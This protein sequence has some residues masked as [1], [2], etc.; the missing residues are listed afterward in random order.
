MEAL[1][2]GWQDSDNYL[3]KPTHHI[4]MVVYFT[5]IKRHSACHDQ[6]TKILYFFFTW[7]H[8]YSIKCPKRREPSALTKDDTVLYKICKDHE[9]NG[10][11]F[12]SLDS[13]V[14]SFSISKMSC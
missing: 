9:I 1:S 7:H 3:L 14:N 11:A 13:I 5:S 12:L 6:A 2:L 10:V 4:Y 8:I